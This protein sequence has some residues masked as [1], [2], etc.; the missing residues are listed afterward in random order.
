MGRRG[1]TVNLGP[2][3]VNTG[4]ITLKAVGGEGV[5]DPAGRDDSAAARE[6][7]RKVE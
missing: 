5:D 3:G 4:A 7:L 2:E 6:V 1:G